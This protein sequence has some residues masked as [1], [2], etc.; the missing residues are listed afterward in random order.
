MTESALAACI[1]PVW[2]S[3]SSFADRFPATVW[4]L[5]PAEGED[6]HAEGGYV[7]RQSMS[8]LRSGLELLFDGIESVHD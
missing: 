6:G 5:T 4:L 7:A 3:P 2:S 8:N 1:A